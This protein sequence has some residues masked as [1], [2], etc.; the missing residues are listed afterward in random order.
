M[1]KPLF[2]HKYLL[3]VVNKTDQHWY[4]IVVVNLHF[5]KETSSGLYEDESPKGYMILDSVGRWRDDAELDP[6]NG[7]LLFMNFAKTLYSN[8]QQPVDQLTF[9][10]FWGSG[11]L[12]T[13]RARQGCLGWCWTIKIDIY[14][15]KMH[16]IVEQL[17]VLIWH[18]SSTVCQKWSSPQVL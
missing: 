7:F 3:Y 6:Q 4:V 8:R 16:T 2:S 17:C 9:Q 18:T 15:N 10:D 1:G 5:L 12:R 13:R 14:N 11:R